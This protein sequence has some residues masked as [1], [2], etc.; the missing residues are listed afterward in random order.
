MDSA[1]L[2]SE[3]EIIAWQLAV[4]LVAAHRVFITHG[5]FFKDFFSAEEIAGFLYA[6]EANPTDDSNLFV[7]P[8]A[9][10]HASSHHSQYLAKNKASRKQCDNQTIFS[11]FWS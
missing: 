4:V 10:E 7:D 8:L 9:L 2:S 6:P 1:A 11:C 5:L 3:E